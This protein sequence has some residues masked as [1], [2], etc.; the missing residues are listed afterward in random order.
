MKL[1]VG[2]PTATLGGSLQNHFLVAMPGMQD[3]RFERTVIYVCAHGSDGAMGIV[4]NR[5]KDV[6]FQDVLL[7]LGILDDEESIRLPV[8]ARNMAVRN[9]GPVD[10]GRG[11]VLHSGDYQVESSMPV[12]DNVCLTATIDILKAISTGHGP[13]QALMA[14]G[15]S[16]W[17]GGQL[18]AE[19]AENGWLACPATPDLLFDGDLE[20]TYD[21]VLASIGVD[22][23]RLSQSAG[24]A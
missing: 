23:L 6:G 2:T 22:P 20:S 8:A 24:H 5:S 13:R 3:E 12:S 1:D 15:Y 9:G 21:R 4:I 11:F 16:G 18:E 10:K 17:A 7:E 19:I 14:L